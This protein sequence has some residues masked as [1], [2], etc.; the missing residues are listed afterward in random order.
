MPYVT[1]YFKT[2]NYRLIY[3]IQILK[4]N[5]FALMYFIQLNDCIKK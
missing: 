4:L 3:Y 5:L 2:L 1:L